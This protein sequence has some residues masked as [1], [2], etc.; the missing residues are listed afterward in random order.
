[1]PRR[2]WRA[3]CFVALLALTACD[4]SLDAA[5]RA[6]LD[7]HDA[8]LRELPRDFYRPGLGD[9]MHALQVRHAKLWFAGTAGNWELG[10]FE[11]EE[12][13]ESLDRVARWHADSEEFAMAPAVKAYM[14]TGRYALEQSIGRRSAAD[15]PAA[16]DRFTN[17]CNEC[18][19]AA[20]HGFIVIERP[21]A[22]PYANQRWA[23]ESAR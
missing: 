1:M 22:P 12:L 9:L 23:P 13:R 21:A 16:F 4:A 20:K 10:A 15:F 7:A 11:M 18:H 2:T 8:V 6:K 14:Q 17:G 19:L 5:S 3:A